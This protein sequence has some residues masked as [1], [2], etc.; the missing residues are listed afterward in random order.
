[1]KKSLFARWQANFWAGLVI[2]LPGFISLAVLRWL[3]LT[4][5]NIT[6][7]L[8]FFLPARLTHHDQ[9][10]GPMY[11][12]WSA[13]A[14]LLAVFLIGI[15][16]LLARNYFGRKIIEW[17]DSALMRIPLLNKIYSATKQVNEAFSS[18]NKSAFRTVALVEFPHPGTYSIGFIT[19][20][21]QQEVQDKTGLKVVCV[22]VPATPNPTS[23]FLLMVPEEKVIKLEMSVADGIKYV[24]SLGA[25]MPGYTPALNPSA[26]GLRGAAS[27]SPGHD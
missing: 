17:V 12:Y 2:V 22:F 8:L 21:Q 10:V 4:F 19:S 23:G 11:W 3:F 26:W 7:T 14:L 6:D 1:M 13:A 27:G 20:E 16:G 24:I 9:G 25:I 15:V 5:A 18:S